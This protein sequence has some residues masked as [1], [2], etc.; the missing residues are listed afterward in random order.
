V[1]LMEKTTSPDGPN[2]IDAPRDGTWTRK[3]P[4]PVA[5]AEVGV[6]EVE[7]K[8]YVIGGSEQ[9]GQDPPT[10]SSTHNM[11]YSPA[12]DRWQE[13]A[14]LPQALGH[15][16]V[17]E[18]GG[19]LYA[20]GGFTADVHMHP[21]SV[22]LVYDPKIDRWSELQPLSSPRGS[23]AVAAFDGKL[24]IFGG[25]T[26]EKVVKRSTPGVPDMFI[27][28]GT[29]TT[30]EIYDPD[31]G[32]WS[33]SVPLPGPPRDHMG[34]AVVDEKIHVFGG[35]INDFRDL[36][37]RHDV[38]DPKANTWTSA[39]PLPRP[40]SAGAFT[41]LNGLIIY[42]GGE[43]KPG[44]E[45]ATRNAF[46]DVS[47]YDPKTDT[48]TTL[49]PLPQGRHAFGAATAAGVAYF[50]GG[51]LVC[52]GGVSTTELLGLTL[53]T[54]TKQQGDRMSSKPVVVN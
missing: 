44:G 54:R 15:V 29:V 6:G 52:G 46:E 11:M 48:W 30:H 21:Q 45:I 40:R 43:C 10:G 1:I 33:Q 9:R 4:L 14:P 27:G 18:L 2:Q 37:A 36:Q 13:R 8:I 47:A 22:A 28:I 26:S 7:G 49:T 5:I 31:K 12:T 32:E 35:R 3:A 23:V 34:I 50:A 20:I 41:V 24:H 39:S 51:A 38:Y 17:A 25:R 42:A 19:K 53:I 16:G